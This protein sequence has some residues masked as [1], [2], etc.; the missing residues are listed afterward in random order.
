[1]PRIF[2]SYRRQDSS[3][4]T[5]WLHD[6]L[7]AEF[8]TEQIFLDLDAIDAGAD[9]VE[10]IN[11]AVGECDVLIA[12]IG[13]EWLTTADP[14]GRRRLDDPADFVRLEIAA[15][16]ERDVKVIPALVAG[17]APP[18]ADQLPEP[19]KGL[20]NHQALELTDSRWDY[21]IGRLIT[22]LRAIDGSSPAPP[23]AVADHRP[24][25][26]GRGTWIAAGAVAAVLAAG[27]ALV[28]LLGG[29]GDTTTTTT[30]Q[31][32]SAGNP[33]VV[34]TDPLGKEVSEPSTFAFSVNGDLV[35]HDLVWSGWGDPSGATSTGTFEIRAEGVSSIALPGTLLLSELRQCLGKSYYTRADVKLPRDA[36]FQPQ[37]GRLATPCT[38]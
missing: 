5:G 33:D 17:A 26:G 10:R 23:P 18:S 6:R 7:A 4:Y 3:G 14:T 11:H 15:G 25:R 27:A 30:A 12:V 34:I 38:S 9:F 31:A 32:P 24:Q 1:M 2:I 22:Q 21:D 37:V 35:G 36:P 28:L 13:D 16:L 29:G 19:I 8:G 20:A